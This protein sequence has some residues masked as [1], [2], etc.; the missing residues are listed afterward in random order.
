MVR[1]GL[2]ERK[3]GR[4]DLQGSLELDAHL[5]AT[6]A[7]LFLEH[8]YEGAS[9]DQ[10]AAA[11]G[12]GKQSL[13]RRY[14]NKEA[15]FRT[16]FIDHLARERL[17]RWRQMTAGF[18]AT[19]LDA[20]ADPMDDLRRVA[21]ATFDFAVEPQSVEVFRLYVAERRRFPGLHLEVGR[22]SAAL[23]VELDRRIRSAQTLGLLRACAGAFA[24][25]NL[26]ALVSEGPTMQALL[27]LQS[28]ES[29]AC[30]GAYFEAAWRTFTEAMAIR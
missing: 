23:E 6:A 3:K 5:M 25:R 16:V 30:R 1:T 28:L 10:V 21:R 19:S 12:A 18:A 24:A 8:G 7:R 11:A 9:M 26:L 13:Y 15:L 17:S 27:G 29:E 2:A 4:P 20:L 14:P 22:I